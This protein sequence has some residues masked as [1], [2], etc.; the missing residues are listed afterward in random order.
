MVALG[1]LIEDNGDD[2][3][4]LRAKNIVC[5]D[6]GKSACLEYTNVGRFAISISGYFVKGAVVRAVEGTH[7]GVRSDA[8]IVSF[9]RNI[10]R[11]FS[12]NDR[13]R[14]EQHGHS[15]F[16][17]DT[18]AMFDIYIP[19]KATEFS[20]KGIPQSSAEFFV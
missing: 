17:L 18:R 12:S 16:P 20:S 1:R 4:E 19:N 5:R 2:A 11:A 3:V 15:G 8:R 13:Q 9:A 6:V 10:A 14:G 7:S